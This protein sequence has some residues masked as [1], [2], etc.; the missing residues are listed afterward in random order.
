MSVSLRI[1]LSCGVGYD[2]A[3]GQPSAQRDLPDVKKRLLKLAEKFSR[4]VCWLGIRYIG[5]IF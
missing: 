2:L 5:G 3:T 1:A 4:K